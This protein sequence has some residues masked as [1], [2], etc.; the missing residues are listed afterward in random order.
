MAPGF[1]PGT[2]NLPV[3]KDE[4]DALKTGAMSQLSSHATPPVGG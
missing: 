1:D 2:S 4:T 3:K